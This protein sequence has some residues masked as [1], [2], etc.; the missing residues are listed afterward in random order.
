MRPVN[1]NNT[2]SV[3]SQPKKE[4]SDDDIAEQ[5]SD[6]YEEDFEDAS[7]GKSARKADNFFKEDKKKED[8]KKMDKQSDPSQNSGIGFN[9][10]YEDADFF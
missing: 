9:D 2:G 10:D 6:N 5:I 4:K 1:L 7:A 8:K 3:I